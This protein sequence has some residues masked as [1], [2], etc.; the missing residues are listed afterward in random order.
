MN[1]TFLRDTGGQT[2]IYVA[3]GMVVLLAFVAL[4]VDVGHIYAESRRMQ[5]AADAGALA[6]AQRLCWFEGEDSARAA[7][8]AYAQ[9][10]GAEQVTPLIDGWEVTAVVT[11]TADLYFARILGINQMAVPAIAKAQ[12][13]NTPTTCGLWPVAFSLTQWNQHYNGGAGCGKSFYV[14]T[15]DQEGKAGEPAGP[16]CST[17]DDACQCDVDDDGTP[18]IFS[19]AGR[20]WIDFS[21]VIDPRYPDGCTKPGG[22]GTD[23]LMCHIEDDSD[24][25]LTLPLCFAGDKGKKVGVKKSVDSRA[26]DSVKIPLYS[27]EG[28]G[29]P[30]GGSN[31]S[32]YWVTQFG[33]VTV[34]PVKPID[35]LKLTFR[36]TTLHPGNQ[37][38]W[39][40][41][42]I[43]VAINCAS[44]ACQTGCGRPIGTPVPGGINSV[45]LTQ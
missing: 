39:E 20:A 17:G 43:K 7:T 24:S 15:G 34:A 8:I 40:D 12:C 23:E 16:D 26:G 27:S 32:S 9:Q 18:D 42:V 3:I 13:G 2:L 31:G 30:C 22:C 28:C 36:N 4:A 45:G 33:C 10:N 37:K 29:E 1:R 38:C 35:K 14:W 11:E 41:W 44:G 5:N 21:D 19:E 6:G 25:R